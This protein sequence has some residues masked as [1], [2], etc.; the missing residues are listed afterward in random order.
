L[1][2]RFLL[3]YLKDASQF[4]ASFCGLAVQKLS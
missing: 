4:Q 1:L 2:G 3:Q